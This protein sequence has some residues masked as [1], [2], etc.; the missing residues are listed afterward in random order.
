MPESEKDPLNSI[1]QRHIEIDV[2]P[3]R[4]FTQFRDM[5]QELKLEHDYQVMGDIVTLKSDNMKMPMTLHEYRG[6]PTDI[7]TQVLN[8]KLPENLAEI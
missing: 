2:S 1:I 6:Q 4:N 5:A 8:V 7:F 3:I